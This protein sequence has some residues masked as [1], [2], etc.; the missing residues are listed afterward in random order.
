MEI[1]SSIWIG[2][3]F[4][5]CVMVLFPDLSIRSTRQES[6]GQRGSR[7]PTVEERARAPGVEEGAGHGRWV[8]AVEEAA[9][10]SYFTYMT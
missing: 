2:G 8:S 5:C 4:G 3:S 9:I 1:G 7:A 10:F 6:A